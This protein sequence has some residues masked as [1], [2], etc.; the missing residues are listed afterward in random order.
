MCDAPGVNGRHANVIDELLGNQ[1][2]RVPDRGENFADRQWRRRMLAHDSVP[3]LQFARY[4]VFKP[5]Q[6][7]GF[8]TFSKTRRFDRREAMMSIVQEMN[9]VSELHAKR[10]K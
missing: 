9:V 7:I 5:E 4:S 8:E 2:S 6:M 1:S 10:L 3:F